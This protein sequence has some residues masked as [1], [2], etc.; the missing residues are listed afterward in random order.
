MPLNTRAL[1]LILKLKTTSDVRTLIAGELRTT[2]GSRS[3]IE[4]ITTRGAHAGTSNLTS[5]VNSGRVIA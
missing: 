5:P 2:A 3:R 4:G 1:V